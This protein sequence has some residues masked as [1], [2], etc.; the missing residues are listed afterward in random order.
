MIGWPETKP[1]VPA[2][3]Q[4]WLAPGTARMLHKA[5]TRHDDQVVLE[6]GVWLGKSTKY[7]LSHPEVKHVYSVDHWDAE[8]LVPW[9]K[10]RHPHLVEAAR[11]AF[12]TFAV[13]LWDQR[14]RI[15]PMRMDSRDAVAHIEKQSVGVH[16]DVVYLDT[17]HSYPHTL[18]EI[19][20]ITK[21]F[22]DAVLVGDDW[23]YRDRKGVAAVEKSVREF[24][25]S[26]PQYGLTVDENGWILERSSR[27]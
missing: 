24:L 10:S 26:N 15:T 8:R 27:N 13:N 17:S 23:L 20:A 14:E 7:I 12:E 22:P 4:G 25:R 2:L 21:A 16:P 3:D 18:H 5:L 9:T 6:L 19:Q 1:D 11:H